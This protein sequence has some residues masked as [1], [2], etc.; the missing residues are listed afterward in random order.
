MNFDLS[1]AFWIFITALG[2]AGIMMPVALVAAAWLAVGYRWTYAVAWL[3]MLGAAGTLVA[4]SKIAFMGWGVG[5]RGFDFTGVSG[6][7]LMATAVLPVAAFVAMMPMRDTLRASGVATGLLLG[8]LVSTS[9]VVLN[10]HSVSEA[11]TGWMLGAAVA[12]LFVRLAWKAER[13]LLSPIPVAATLL[14]IVIALY[15]VPVPTQRWLA[16][17]A[18]GLS[19]NARPYERTSLQL[20]HEWTSACRT[21]CISFLTRKAD[22]RGTN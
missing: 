4:A 21:R 8:V 3:A 14:A 12:L 22:F 6:H 16:E 1:V 5:V 11:A 15:G 18:I 10:A 2:S 13:R 9:R 20:S 7:S 19:G 17:I